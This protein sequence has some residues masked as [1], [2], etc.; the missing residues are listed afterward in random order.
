ME[1]ERTPE[2]SGRLL[3]IA[4]PCY[5]S[6]RTEISRWRNDPQSATVFHSV[7][8]CATGSHRVPEC[9]TACHSVSQC[10]TVRYF[11][12]IFYIFLLSLLHR[13]IVIDWKDEWARRLRQFARY[14]MKKKCKRDWKKDFSPLR[15]ID[16]R[17]NRVVDWLFAP[18]AWLSSDWLTRAWSPG[19]WFTIHPAKRFI[20]E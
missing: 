17:E 19:A 14:E 1:D 18:S 8:Q 6:E 5:P 15:I 20:S 9:A 7:P 11:R 4:R 16:E 10:A 2:A 13:S 12:S 3:V